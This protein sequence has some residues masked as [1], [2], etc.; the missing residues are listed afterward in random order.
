MVNGF[1]NF[2][3]WKIKKIFPT[4][5]L[6][7]DCC[8]IFLSR[9]KRSPQEK[10][11]GVSKWQINDVYSR[12]KS[13]T[14]QRKLRVSASDPELFGGDDNWST[15]PLE[16]R[17]TIL[18]CSFRGKFQFGLISTLSRCCEART[19]IS[20]VSEKLSGKRKKR[21]TRLLAS[22]VCPSNVGLVDTKGFRPH[23]WKRV[24]T[25]WR[26]IHTRDEVE[27]VLNWVDELL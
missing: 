19:M 1:L 25:T 15:R 4:K 14:F 12:D 26:A 16:S 21:L 24:W 18:V 5:K 6:F 3:P 13:C 2:N 8:H 23:G 20:G 10:G 27:F 11:C 9:R 7:A 22:G 17:L